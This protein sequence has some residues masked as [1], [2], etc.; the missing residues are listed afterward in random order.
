MLLATAIAEAGPSPD[1]VRA[2]LDELG[3]TRPPFPGVSGPISFEDGPAGNLVMV[4]VGN[5]SIA[6]RQSR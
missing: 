3:V 1:A 5:D 2:Y 6:A 4:S